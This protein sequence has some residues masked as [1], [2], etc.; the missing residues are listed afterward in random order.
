MDRGTGDGSIN[1]LPW[2]SV[3]D[4]AANARALSAIQAQG[5]RAASEIVDRFAR[6]TTTGLS[7]DAR[8]TT[9][10]GPFTDDQRADLFGATDIEPLIRSW[11]VMIGQFLLGSAPRVPDPDSAH[12]ASLD[13]SNAA[14]EGRLELAATS[15]GTA[16]AEV[17]LHN[18]ATADL[19][20]IQLRCSDLLAHDGSV[21]K[22]GAV[23]FEPSAVAMPGRSSRGIEMSIEVLQ[24]VQPGTYRGTLLAQRHPKLW[25]PVVLTVRVP[26]T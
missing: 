16:K 22:S 19:G 23:M 26:L 3:F 20:Q 25:L 17:W 21:V 1:D 7:R 15:P 4:P 12:E 6:I 14:I 10:A 5:F 9:S 8:S 13:F 11:W 24:G 2:A 18:R